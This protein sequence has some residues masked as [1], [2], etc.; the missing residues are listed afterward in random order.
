MTQFAILWNLPTVSANGVFH[1]FFF[2]LLHYQVAKHGNFVIAC[3]PIWIELRDSSVVRLKI[4][5]WDFFSS[6]LR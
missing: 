1:R 5:T 4:G 6:K 2:L 3:Q